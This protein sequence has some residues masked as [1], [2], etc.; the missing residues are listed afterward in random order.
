MERT[1]V[2]LCSKHG[3]GAG[4]VAACS[5]LRV[6][7]TSVER[8]ERYLASPL[9]GVGDLGLVL[10]H[11][12]GEVESPLEAIFLAQVVYFGDFQLSPQVLVIADDGREHRVDF[13][14]KGSFYAIELD[15]N[16]K[17]GDVPNLQHFNLAKEKE[18]A[19][20]LTHGK[21]KISRFDYAAV[22]KGDAYRTMLRRLGLPP[23]AVLPVIHF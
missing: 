22:M 6:R 17:Y 2:D 5:A 8:L 15:G 23:R 4:F 20:A 7:K 10:K 19:D 3:F 12:T 21:I 14:V 9:Y 1:I 13:G 18:R 11:A 16:E